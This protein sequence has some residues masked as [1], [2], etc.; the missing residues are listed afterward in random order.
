[1][2][3]RVRLDGKKVVLLDSEVRFSEYLYQHEM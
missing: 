3:Q 2:Y 1:M